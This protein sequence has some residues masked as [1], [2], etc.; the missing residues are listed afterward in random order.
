MHLVPVDP[1]HVPALADAEA[2]PPDDAPH[3]KAL[4]RASTE[5][6]EA[7]AALHARFI[8]DGSHALLVVLQARDAGGKDG[9]VRHVFSGLDPK[10]CRVTAFE[11]PAGE[12]TRHDYLW[13]AHAACP[14]RGVVGIFNRSHYEDVL[15]ARV[16][17]LVPEAVWSRRYRHIAEFERLLADE[18]TA[19]V[20]LF[21]HVSRAEQARRLRA[22][23]DAPDKNYKYDPGDLDDRARWDDYTRAYRDVLR[24]TAARRAPWYVVPADDKRV[25]NYLV[26]G[27][28]VRALEAVCPAPREFAPA[29]L[30]ALR[31]GLEARLAEEGA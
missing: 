15:V 5:R 16:R 23:L 10:A 1:D 21:L 26:A 8:A 14:P 20:K 2:T 19:V 12:E 25:R 11:A 7:L 4:A 28:L 31:A 29:R 9:T 18:G 22:R 6:L 13:R 27:V 17:G 30:A 24:K 3:G